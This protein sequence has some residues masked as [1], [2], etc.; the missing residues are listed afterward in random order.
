MLQQ[1]NNVFRF[2]LV[3]SVAVTYLSSLDSHK[4]QAV[5]ALIARLK[6]F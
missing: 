6:H 5:A 1:R 2:S 3:L 4:L